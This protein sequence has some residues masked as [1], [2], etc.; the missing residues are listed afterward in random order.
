MIFGR[1]KSS[2]SH[3]SRSL[4]FKL[5]SLLFLFSLSLFARQAQAV[6]CTSGNYRDVGQ[7]NFCIDIPNNRGTYGEGVW[8]RAWVDV[9]CYGGGFGCR[10]AREQIGF[11]VTSAIAVRGG[12]NANGELQLLL[13][14]GSNVS[15]V[16]LKQGTYRIRA[17]T[18]YASSPTLEFTITEQ[19]TAVTLTPSKTTVKVGEQ[20]SLKAETIAY[21]A[22]GTNTLLYGP[23]SGDINL[24]VAESVQPKK[25]YYG[26]TNEHQLTIFEAGEFVFRNTFKPDD[27]N[28]LSSSGDVTV[29][30]ERADTKTTLTLGGSGA[31]YPGKPIALIANV[32]GVAAQRT[33]TVKFYRDFYTLMGTAEVVDGV[34]TLYYVPQQAEYLYLHAEYVGDNMYNGSVSANSV[35]E[36]SLIDSTLT[37]TTPSNTVTFGDTIRVQVKAH[38][39]RPSGPVILGVNG[40]YYVAD[41]NQD[42]IAE[43]IVSNLDV[44]SNAI[45]ALYRGDKA[46]N[47]SISNVS[48]VQ[49]TPM[50]S[51]IDLA[52]S[53][54]TGATPGSP[55]VLM[56][57]LSG[58]A[59]GRSG[60]V[61]FYDGEVFLGSQSVT[62]NDVIFSTTLL[63]SLGDHSITAKYSGDTRHSSAASAALNIKIE[64]AK[65]EV[66]LTS[67]ANPLINGNPVSISAEVKGVDPTG[68]VSF[69]EKDKLLAEVNLEGGVARLDTSLIRGVGVHE[70]K[71]VYAGDSQNLPAT[72]AVFQQTVKFNPAHL[73]PILQLL[74]N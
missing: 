62:T 18:Y 55:V 26:W 52:A 6:E 39:Y 74:L 1:L 53:P 63:K 30:V 73:T 56:V 21:G 16:T 37:L 10:D 23:K 2:H 25:N 65:S 64:L 61:S 70:I 57:K 13:K 51:T 40:K 19:G 71:A 3:F 49:V 8:V 32:S 47:V 68:K 43:F 72:S 33:G 22:S 20:F 66:S 59:G 27:P 38:G 67:S 11:S 50:V 12:Y 45:S 28:Y 46:N 15:G 24:L 42:S 7:I 14:G 9:A 31:Y 4:L 29:S 41:L 36:V 69:Y 58:D 17:D 60:T 54:A 35:T 48:T 5:A 34:A 44:G